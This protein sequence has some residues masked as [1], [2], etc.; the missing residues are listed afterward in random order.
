MKGNKFSDTVK[1]YVRKVSDDD[2]RFLH[3]RLTQRIGGDVAEA[4][5]FLQRYQELDHWLCLA[6]TANDFFDMVDVLDAGMQSEMKRRFSLHEA[7]EKR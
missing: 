4:I 7:K 5:E 2:L 3:M 6:K 1:E